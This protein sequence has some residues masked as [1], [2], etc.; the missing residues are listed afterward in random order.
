MILQND[1]ASGDGEI[2]THGDDEDFDVSSGD[3]DTTTHKPSTEDPDDYDDYD[4]EDKDVT[5]ERPKK[6]KPT[7]DEDLFEGSGEEGSG[8]EVAE[9]YGKFTL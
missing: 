4:D 3:G 7:D 1:G 5:T 9:P 6:E 8:K 2:G